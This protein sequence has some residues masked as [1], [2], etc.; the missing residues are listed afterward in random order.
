MRETLGMIATQICTLRFSD[1]STVSASVESGSPYE[2]SVVRYTGAVQRLPEQ[3]PLASP[4]RLRDFF[5]G[6]A[7]TLGAGYEEDVVGNWSWFAEDEELY[8]DP[9][10][11]AMEL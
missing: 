8:P 7:T 10:P 9:C 5:Q 3:C 2:H 11:G 4:E 1:G 6:C